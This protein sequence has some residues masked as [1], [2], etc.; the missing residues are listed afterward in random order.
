[1]K[2]FLIFV[3]VVLL[4][5]IQAQTNP[6]LSVISV[7]GEGI[8]HVTPDHA[9][10][11]VRLEH[12]GKEAKEVQEKNNFSVNNVIKSL[13]EIKLDMKDV[14]TEFV[15][16]G[17]NYD[18]ETKQYQYVANQTIVITVRDLT[19]YELIMNRLLDSGINRIDNVSFLSKD[20]EKH[21]SE[22]R[23]KAITNAR[24]KALDYVTV[25]GQELGK[26]TTIT[27]VKGYQ[28]RPMYDVRMMKSSMNAESQETIAIGNMEVKSEVDVVFVLK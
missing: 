6:N 18:Y 3:S 28:P 24:Q 12:E 25:L 26:A 14:S 1:M 15:N 23:Q 4:S 9:L 7:G 21:K 17:K 11:R 8:V 19:K 27:E 16:L 2:H 5:T 22:A 10:I 13:R 20:I